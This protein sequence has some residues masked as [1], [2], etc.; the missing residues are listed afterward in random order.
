MTKFLIPIQ[1]IS[2]VI[3]NSSSEI[4]ICQTDN[5]K[6]VAETIKEVL[7]TVYDSLKKARSCSGKNTLALYEENLDGILSITVAD[8]DYTDSGWGYSYKKGDIIIESE[9]DNSIPSILMDFIYEF[10][11]WNK[12]E[13][14]HLG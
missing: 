12:V 4:F 14:H 11:A 1:N 10:F 6:E 7:T 9:Y 5:P 2:D 13:Q 3:T 8:N